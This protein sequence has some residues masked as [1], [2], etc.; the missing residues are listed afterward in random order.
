[1]ALVDPCSGECMKSELDLFSL[2]PTQTSIEETRIEHCYPLTSLDGD[3]QIEFKVNVGLD[4]FIDLNEIWLYTRNKILDRAGDSLKEKIVNTN[5][6]PD[7]S[8][9]FPINYFQGSM[10]KQV[11]VLLNNSLVQTASLYPYRAFME[12]LLTFGSDTK[13]HQLKASM[14]AKDVK[15]FN[16]HDPTEADETNKGAKTRFQWTKFSKAFESIGRVHVDL[17]QQEKLL[18]NKVTLGLRF[19]RSDP[20]FVLMA[21]DNTKEYKINIERALLLVTVKKIASHTREAIE[22][23]LLETN[24]KYN[25][26]RVDMKFFTKGSER[27]DIS[28][29]NL[30]TG[31]LPSQIIIGLVETDAMNGTL[32][33]NPFAMMGKTFKIQEFNLTVNGVQ[34]NFRP[35]QT[36][37]KGE[38]ALAY[39]QTMHSLGLW[40][41]DKSNC[42]DPEEDFLDGE[43]FFAVNLTQD[44]SNGGNLNLIQEGVVSL[45]LRL[46]EGADKSI[47]IIAYLV[48]SSSVL[49]ITQNREII[50]NE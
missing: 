1:M 46:S 29:N 19:Q 49:E 13:E 7:A 10:F 36:K 25:L 38:T 8:K 16:C 4:E 27:S 43:T 39:F 14:F 22:S 50:Y 15:N 48:Y 6:I 23:R 32:L 42:L 9:V 3:G 18:L 44:L 47:T 35:L 41:K 34:R 12:T 31:V 21:K 24:A 20:K 45:N 5:D 33:K 26:R 30:C 40:T 2:K 11:E 28:I 37:F 17:F